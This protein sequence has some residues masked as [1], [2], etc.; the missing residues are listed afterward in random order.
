MGIGKREF[1]GI[2]EVFAEKSLGIIPGESIW[3]WK[4]G[5]LRVREVLGTRGMG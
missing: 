4:D 1:L 3:A 2:R 5:I